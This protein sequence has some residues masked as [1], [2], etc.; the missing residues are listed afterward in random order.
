MNST[1]K[2]RKSNNFSLILFFYLSIKK[3]HFFAQKKQKNLKD[4]W[5][6]PNIK[7]RKHRIFLLPLL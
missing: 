4:F 3:F 6:T 1:A 7:I 5:H 2:L